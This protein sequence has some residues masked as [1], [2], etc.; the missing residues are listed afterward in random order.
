MG[1]DPDLI[2]HLV[3]A[4]E[5]EPFQKKAEYAPSS[6]AAEGFLHASG[7]LEQLL[8][9]ANRRFRDAA[10]MLVLCIDR[11]QVRPEIRY[12]DGGHTQPFPHL[13]GPLNTDAIVEVRE[14]KRDGSGRFVGF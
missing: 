10:K 11:A 7:S 3:P 13:Y 8:W 1:D 12:E 6:L 4:A 14:L 9:V 2:Y 5:W